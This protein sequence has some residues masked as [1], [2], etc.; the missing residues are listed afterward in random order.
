L[1]TKLQT[2]ELSVKKL[3]IYNDLSR[4]SA[5]RMIWSY[6]GS[7]DSHITPVTQCESIRIYLYGTT[8]VVVGTYRTSI[9]IGFS[10]GFRTFPLPS[11]LYIYYEF[12][13]QNWWYRPIG[14]YRNM[15]CSLLILPIQ[16]FISIE[17]NTF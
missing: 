10:D 8:S 2:K 9:L 17:T 1:S 3:L 5:D 11:Y 7:Y 4:L 14:I 15:H 16:L 13:N 12:I 6:V